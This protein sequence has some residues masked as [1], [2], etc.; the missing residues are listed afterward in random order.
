MGGD[1]LL[2][3]FKNGNR[4]LRTL[5]AQVVVSTS[6]TSAVH[7]SPVFLG[8]PRYHNE[9]NEMDYCYAYEHSNG[10]PTA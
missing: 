5:V 7:P 4:M 3:S 8:R 10:T 2:K 6:G 9:R 1:L